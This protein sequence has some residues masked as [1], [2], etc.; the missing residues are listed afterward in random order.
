MS[1][2]EAGTSVAALQ[3]LLE[4]KTGVASVRQEVLS[5]FPPKL[6]QVW[7]CVSL[8]VVQRISQARG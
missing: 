6:L 7:C 4:D 3:T 5:G 1:G 8:V 2:L